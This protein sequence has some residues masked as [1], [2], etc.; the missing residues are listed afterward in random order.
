MSYKAFFP[1]ELRY[2]YTLN[3]MLKQHQR[4]KHFNRLL[5]MKVIDKQMLLTPPTNVIDIQNL[6]D[7]QILLH[8]NAA[9]NNYIFIHF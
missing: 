7:T 3:F 4:H 8:T 2:I 6:I 1:I 9:K 5:H